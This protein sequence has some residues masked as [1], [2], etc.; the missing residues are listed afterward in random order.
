MLSKATMIM[1]GRYLFDKVKGTFGGMPFEGMGTT[2]YDN[3]RKKFVATWIDSM[4]TGIMIG[5]GDYDA[6]KKSWSYT[7]K[8]TEPMSG[9]SILTRSV[10]RIVDDNTWVMEMYGPGP[11]GK[12]FQMMEITYH[13][14]AK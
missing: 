4:G 12:E 5:E 6:D 7:A 3:G 9:Q 13:R 11:D 14:N 10:E 8:S 1:D 2:G